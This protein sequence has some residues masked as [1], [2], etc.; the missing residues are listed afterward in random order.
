MCSEKKEFRQIVRTLVRH[1]HRADAPAASKL[2]A[3][4]DGV[5]VEED[6]QVHALALARAPEPHSDGPSGMRLREVCRRMRAGAIAPFRA[7]PGTKPGSARM[8]G[9]LSAVGERR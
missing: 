9:A 4:A 3:G 1:G 5:F 6:G 7:I 2:G 8:Q